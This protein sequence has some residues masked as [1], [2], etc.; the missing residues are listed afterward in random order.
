MRKIL[1]TCLCGLFSAGAFAAP[2]TYNIDRA[3]TQVI[4]MV[5]HFGYS[6]SLL[7]FPDVQGT[8]MLDFDNPTQSSLDVTINTENVI[9]GVDKLDGHL[10]K[11]D[12][13][14]VDEFPTAHFVSTDFSARS[15]TTG[16][17]TGELTLLG[18]THPLTFTVQLNQ[19]KD[20]PF[21]GVDAVGYSAK[22]VIDR[23]MYGMGYGIPGIA[24]EVQVLIEGESILAK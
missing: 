10:K 5:S 16:T 23:S 8:M 4:V 13:L 21:A 14:H 17:V 22:A 11:Q 19:R 1:L 3:H 6:K 20:H 7:L 24:R 15:E 9:T 2:Q 18:Q 12:F